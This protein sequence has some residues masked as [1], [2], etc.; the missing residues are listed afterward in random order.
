MPSEIA[1]RLPREIAQRYLT[2][3]I[4]LGLSLRGEFTLSKPE[5]KGCREFSFYLAP[6]P[7]LGGFFFPFSILL[8]YSIPTYYDKAPGTLAQKL[9]T[10]CGLPRMPREIVKRYLI[11]VRSM[12]TK[13][14][15]Y[16]LSGFSP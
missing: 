16:F 11:G 13:S 9:Y 12:K 2:G 14:N 1:K 8:C 6:S 4:S 15:V 7:V 3:V 5:A 10:N